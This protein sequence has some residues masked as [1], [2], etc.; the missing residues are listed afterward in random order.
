[1][2]ISKDE[3]LELYLKRKPN[4]CFVSNYFD[5][6][7]K[8]WQ[9]NMGRQLVFHEYKAVTYMCQCFS[10]TEHQCSQAMKQAAKATFENNMYHD[11]M[12]TIVKAYLSSRVLCSGSSL[13]Y[14]VR[15]EVKE[16][17]SSCVFC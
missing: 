4:S 14:F 9:A 3:D 8:A 12:K 11:T 2:S 10:K 17:L 16:N 13:L 5:S 7:L 1:M 15:I 6:Y